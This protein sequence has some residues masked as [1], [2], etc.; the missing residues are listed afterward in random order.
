MTGT[1]TTPRSVIVIGG[2]LAGFTTAK[3]LR[4]HGYEGDIT[5]I[6]PGGLPYDRPPLSK[7]FLMGRSTA[8]SLLFEPESWYE[9][10]R[11]RVVK[12]L[13]ERLRAD[14]GAVV[15]ESGAEVPT[16]VVVLTTGGL[17]RHLPVPGGE[18]AGLRYLRTREDAERL[19]SIIAPGRRFGIIGAGLIGAEVASTA[20][21]HGMDVVLID[22]APL[23]L[24]P[25]IGPEIAEL[26]HAMH[27]PRGIDVR[28]G[29]T[30]GISRDGDQFAIELDG[31]HGAGGHDILVDEVLVGIG[32]VPETSLGASAGLEMD[33]GVLVDA[34]QRTTNSAIFAAGDSART[35]LPDGT[36]LRRHEHWESA[37]HEGQSAAAGILGLEPPRHGAEWFWSDRHGVHVEGVGSMGVDGSTVL[38]LREGRPQM[39]FRL[40]PDGRMAGAVAV[41]GGMTV[42]VARR[43]IDRGLTV[44]PDKLADPSIDLKKL[45]R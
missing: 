7:D 43:I 21:D 25:A 14:T 22:P 24:A 42:R 10:N 26:L 39:A 28:V 44:D 41:D 18:L 37:L 29:M 38:R 4:G 16:D 2:G 40:T 33:N 5:I 8:E 11:I 32:I 12:D 31:G 23:P 20:I 36:L 15:L 13:A 6:D 17:P 1:G 9:E 3:E 45:A 19:R 35:R 34:A 30:S 27:A